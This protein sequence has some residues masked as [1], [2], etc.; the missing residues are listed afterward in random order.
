MSTNHRIVVPSAKRES[1]T[2]NRSTGPARPASVRGCAGGAKMGNQV[3]QR[4]SVAQAKLTVSQPGDRFER[5]ADQVADHVMRMPGPALGQ[6]PQIQRLCSEC[7]EQLHRKEAPEAQVH[8]FQSA[9]GA[10]FPESERSYFEPRFGRDFGAVRIHTDAPAAETART[11]GALAFTVGSDIVFARGQYA[12]HTSDGR[13]LLAHELTHVV[14]QTQPVPRASRGSATGEASGMAAPTTAPAPAQ[15]QR[16]VRASAL[17]GCG[18]RNP[19]A[20]DRRASQ[21]LT[22]ALA[23]IDAASAARPGDPADAD[24]VAIGNAMHRAFRLGP[25][26]DD[27]WNL[28]APHFGLPLVRRRLEIARNYIDSVVFTINCC[29]VGGACPAT[30]G[31][32]AAGEEAFVC[33]QETSTITLCPGFWA[34]GA[35]Q[36]GRTL[37][38]EVLHINFGFVQDWTSPD[39][40]NAHCYAQFVALANGFNSPAGFRCH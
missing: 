37:L 34:L 5:E 13:R 14:Q 2:L 19:H 3:A 6:P 16:L 40:S 39:Q 30:C 23:R 22:N 32:C 15:V 26:N 28:A 24:V 7:E 1:A 38:H 25:A 27:N 31:T 18:A 4:L 33:G 29:T 11:L 8:D 35:N 10:F 17:V 20:A 9:G 36:R 21:L 12:P